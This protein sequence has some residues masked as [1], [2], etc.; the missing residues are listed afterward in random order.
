MS[1]Q[2]YKLV[3]TQKMDERAKEVAMNLQRGGL[4]DNLMKEG[5]TTGKLDAAKQWLREQGRE[6]HL[7]NAYM[8]YD[9]D[10]PQWIVT[11]NLSD[12]DTA[13]LLRLSLN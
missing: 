13:I 6:H 9:F 4:L 11:I 1:E 8:S 2:L 7:I 3:L 12:R 10:V 5:W